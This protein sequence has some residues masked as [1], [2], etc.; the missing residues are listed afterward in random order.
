M[1]LRVYRS[2]MD[3][4]SL[5]PAISPIVSL[6]V[7]IILLLITAFFVTVR[8]TA[9]YLQNKRLFSDDCKLNLLDV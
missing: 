1:K 7:D 5:R 3:Y 2:T 4:T 9:Q 8:V 6:G